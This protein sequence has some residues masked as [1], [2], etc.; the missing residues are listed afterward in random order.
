MNDSDIVLIRFTVTGTLGKYIT[1][2]GSSGIKYRIL[3]TSETAHLKKGDDVC[4]HVTKIKSL[5]FMNVYR[6][7]TKQEVS[8]MTKQNPSKTLKEL[9]MKLDDILKKTV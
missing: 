1:G 3:K 5:F 2:T 7:L 8:E 4:H 6:F 9:G